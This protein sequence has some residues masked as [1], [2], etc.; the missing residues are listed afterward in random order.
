[1][2]EL[3]HYQEARRV[4][5]HCMRVEAYG[6]VDEL[7]AWIGLLRDHKENHNTKRI[8]YLYSGPAYETVLLRLHATKIIQ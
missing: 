1:M 6:S 3:L 4:P 8:P 5:K 7:I 2:M